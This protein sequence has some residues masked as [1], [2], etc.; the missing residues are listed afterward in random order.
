[1]KKFLYFMLFYF[2]LSVG[3]TVGF[4]FIYTSDKVQET[5]QEEE[6]QREL[7]QKIADF[8]SRH[9]E[10]ASLPP[11]SFKDDSLYP[12]DYYDKTQQLYREEIAF[13]VE[14]YGEEATAKVV[15][16]ISQIPVTG[17]YFIGKIEA[18]NSELRAPFAHKYYPEA[19]D[20]VCAQIAHK[21]INSICDYA[22]DLAIGYGYKQM[23]QSIIRCYKPDIRITK[24]K[25]SDST[26]LDSDEYKVSTTYQSR[27]N[28]KAR[29]ADL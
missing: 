4:Y 10:L 11:R 9:K 8:E 12:D 24:T 23:A 19:F 26:S 6:A 16:L 29:I 25:D 17:Q 18:W 27:D 1:M 3:F 22:L 21:T 13:I 20:A 5:I 7:S 2:I 14:Q 28:A 15:F